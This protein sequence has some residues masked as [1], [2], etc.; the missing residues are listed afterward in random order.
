MP[1]SGGFGNFLKGFNLQYGLQRSF[2]HR[3]QHKNGFS[4]ILNGQ[5]I[6]LPASTV[7]SLIPTCP[8]KPPAPIH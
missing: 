7:F 6:S 4:P 5:V 3:Q 1:I 8:T 2:H